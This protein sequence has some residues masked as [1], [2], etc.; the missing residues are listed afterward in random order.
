MRRKQTHPYTEI[1]TDV[2]THNAHPFSATLDA[3]DTLG[4]ILPTS[5]MLNI[6]RQL[7]NHNPRWEPASPQALSRLLAEISPRHSPSQNATII[8]DFDDSLELSPPLDG[9]SD[10]SDTL[11]PPDVLG[12]I[13]DEAPHQTAAPKP[14]AEEIQDFKGPMKQSLKG[15]FTLWKMNS[16][17][18]GL[19][20]E[21]QRQSFLR[22]VEDVIWE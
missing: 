10:E 8:A 14:S 19:S 12:L 4:E 22:V 9:S 20:E 13:A 21:E 17:R 3:H 15:L 18:A 11:S 7:T 5:N 2:E 6:P 1:D 16:A